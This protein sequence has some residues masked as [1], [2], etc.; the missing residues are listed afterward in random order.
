MSAV[1]SFR[2]G[3]IVVADLNPARGHEQSGRRPVV[4]LTWFQSFGLLIVVPLT[5][6]DKGWWTQVRV[7]RQGSGLPQ[8]SYV[9]CHQIRCL[10]VDRAIS[11]VGPTDSLTL[12]KVKTVLSRIFSL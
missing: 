10:S 6:K 3:D 9:L 5:T 12:G 11:P 1:L 2:A 7:P 4:V 8:D